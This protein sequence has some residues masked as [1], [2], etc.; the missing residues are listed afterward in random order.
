[1]NPSAI[2]R[3]GIVMASSQHIDIRAELHTFF[4]SYPIAPVEEASNIYEYIIVNS[5]FPRPDHNTSSHARP[6]AY[7]CSKEA[8]QE[9][10]RLNRHDDASNERE[11]HETG[12]LHNSGINL[13]GVL[14][15]FELVGV[16]VMSIS[17]SSCYHS[18]GN[19]RQAQIL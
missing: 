5:K 12:V 13:H 19:G 18:Q 9:S 7:V 17:R 10:A 1:M 4:D 6:A 11:S 16:C 8:Q 2:H 14:G 15:G 3:P